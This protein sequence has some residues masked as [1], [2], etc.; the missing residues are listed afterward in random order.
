MANIVA[1]F[2]QGFPSCVGLSRS[3]IL[4]SIG[5]RTQVTQIIASV[6]VFV[7]ILAIGPL[8]SSLPNV[9]KKFKVIRKDFKINI[10]G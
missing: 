3:V 4:D 10:N 5:S 8:F 1:S 7:V 6:L 2:F 9:K